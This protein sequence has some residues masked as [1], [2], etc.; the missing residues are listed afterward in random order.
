MTPIPTCRRKL[1]PKVPENTA[2][3]GRCRLCGNAKSQR[4]YARMRA[5]LRALLSLLYESTPQN[6]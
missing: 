4:A 6:S 3:D 5:K 2:P 1:H